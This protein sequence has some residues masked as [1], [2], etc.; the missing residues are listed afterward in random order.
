M[1]IQIQILLVGVHLALDRPDLGGMQ[2]PQGP[3]EGMG[4]GTG[5]ER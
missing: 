5:M 3:R 2:G 1:I 4:M